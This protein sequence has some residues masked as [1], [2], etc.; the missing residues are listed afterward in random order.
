MKTDKEKINY[1]NQ[2]NTFLGRFA[3]RHFYYEV[4]EK[5]AKRYN[6]NCKKEKSLAV[7][8][9]TTGIFVTALA[10]WL[11]TL[12]GFWSRFFSIICFLIGILALVLGI[13][14]YKR[15]V[16]P[17]ALLKRG[18][19]NAGIIAQI[20]NNCIGLLVL[21][22]TTSQADG[23][24]HWALCSYQLNEIPLVHEKKIGELVPVTCIYGDSNKD[25]KTSVIASPIAWGTNSREVIQKA[26]EGINPIEWNAL[27]KSQNRYDFSA[28][29][30]E[31]EMTKQLEQDEII[32][33]NLDF[34]ADFNKEIK[35]SL[36]VLYE[37]IQAFEN[38]NFSKSALAITTLSELIDE[39]N[40]KEC[41]NNMAKVDNGVY[42]ETY[43]AIYSQLEDIVKLLHKLEDKINEPV[44]DVDRIKSIYE[45]V[46]LSYN[47]II[48]NF[49]KFICN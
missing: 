39:E 2:G 34:M 32:A 8:I 18:I 7:N 37:V 15:V 11:F 27:L 19:L 48:D 46:S 35:E 20:E 26:I 45:S 30:S 40:R 16:S 4:D 47:K 6:V 14:F 23:K 21:A 9:L 24:K 31:I 44:R 10:V 1:T 33:L 43:N 38:K 28:E 17:T 29:Y 42:K 36:M 12:A 25:Y 3:Q 22:E 41:I 13:V 49:E 5:L